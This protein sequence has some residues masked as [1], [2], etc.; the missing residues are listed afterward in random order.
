VTCFL[1]CVEGQGYIAGSPS[2]KSTIPTN[3]VAIFSVLS[4]RFSEFTKSAVKLVIASCSL[5]SFRAQ[6]DGNIVLVSTVKNA[7]Y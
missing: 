2:Y 7:E 5:T 6:S 1:G 4:V 3:R